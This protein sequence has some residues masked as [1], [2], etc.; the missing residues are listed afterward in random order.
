MVKKILIPSSTMTAT[1]SDLEKIRRGLEELCTKIDEEQSDTDSFSALQQLFV[2]FTDPDKR[3]ICT[4]FA[5]SIQKIEGHF[6]QTLFS[7][8]LDEGTTITK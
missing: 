7:D 3:T 5:G 8:L 4:K 2:T 1:P 6:G